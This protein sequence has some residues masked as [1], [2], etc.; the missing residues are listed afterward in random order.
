MALLTTK[1]CAYNH[2]LHLLCK[3][4]MPSMRVTTRKDPA[5]KRANY[6]K[7]ELKMLSKIESCTSHNNAN[8]IVIG[9]VT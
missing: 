7:A 6:D 1:F 8:L 2:H 9:L 3:R 5:S 4:R